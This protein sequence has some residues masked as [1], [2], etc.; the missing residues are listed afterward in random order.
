MAEDVLISKQNVVKLANDRFGTKETVLHY[1][2]IARD[3]GN[4]AKAAASIPNAVSM[5]IELQ[6]MNEAIENV[7]S[8][9]SD[10]KT[11]ITQ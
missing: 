7:M 10:E 3:A 2:R 9:L 11:A 8:L 4:R 5:G 6:T 1:M